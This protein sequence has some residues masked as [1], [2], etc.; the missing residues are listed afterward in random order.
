MRLA[1]RVA[2]VAAVGALA[3]ALGGCWARPKP[4][5]PVTA[6]APDPDARL[7]PAGR[8]RRDVVRYCGDCHGLDR[9]V[10]THESRAAWATTLHRM[11]EN[12]LDL[13]PAQLK[14][15]LGYLAKHYGAA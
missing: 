7:L 5:P 3:L 12:G 1:G 6:P 11:L 4:A 9:V 8:G 14:R 13:T 10:R 2:V 15:M